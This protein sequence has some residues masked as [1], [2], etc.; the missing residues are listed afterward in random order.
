MVVAQGTAQA[1]GGRGDSHGAPRRDTAVHSPRS[2]LRIRPFDFARNSRSSR[3]GA[4]IVV[5]APTVLTRSDLAEA[6][7]LLGIVSL[8]VLGLIA[9]EPSGWTRRGRRGVGS[10]QPKSRVVRWV[11]ARR[12]AADAG[13]E[14]VESPASLQSRSSPPLRDHHR[15]TGP[16][17]TLTSDG[18]PRS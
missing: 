8:P 7:N 10:S 4:G 11:G 17:P 6:A 2:T 9:Y 16:R 1:V 14:R 12:S 15:G 5:V 3:G 18:S 13:H